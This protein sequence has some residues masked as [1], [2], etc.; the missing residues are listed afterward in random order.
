MNTSITLNLHRVDDKKSKA[1]S[2]LVVD[3]LK[4][5]DIPGTQA[6]RMYHQNGPEYIVRKCFLLE[7]HLYKKKPVLDKRRWLM[8]CINNDWNESD[9]FINWYKRK[10]EYI[11][12]NGND[13]LK[14]LISV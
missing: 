2:T 14:Q 4:K 13:D 9:E 11:L 6:V 7:Y 1:K 10:K 3:L 12:N 8:A 5:F